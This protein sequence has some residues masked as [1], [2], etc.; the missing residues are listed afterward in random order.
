MGKPKKTPRS[1][2]TK[3]RRPS[4]KGAAMVGTMLSEPSPGARAMQQRFQLSQ[5]AKTYLHVLANPFD[6][7]TGACVPDE[8]EKP[9][10]KFRSVYRSSLAIG[11]AGFGFVMVDCLRFGLRDQLAITHSGSTYAAITLPLTGAEV[12]AINST[13]NQSTFLTAQIGRGGGSLQWRVVGCG[14]RVRY[15]GTELNRGGSIVPFR[16][17]ENQ[18][19]AG[20]G[21]GNMLVFQTVRSFPTDR[22]WHGTAFTPTSAFDTIYN[23][24]VPVAANTVNVIQDRTIA[25]AITGAVANNSYEYEIIAYYE[26]VGSIIGT[27]PSHSDMAGM[28]VAHAFTAGAN[29][30]TAGPSAFAAATKFVKDLV[31]TDASGWLATGKMVSTA[32]SIL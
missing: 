29:D 13:N 2:N 17:P 8:F 1:K 15:S 28:G 6:D 9:S 18:F 16:H 4:K 32:L 7:V 5:C 24:A 26:I 14:L 22:Q 19:I 23:D 3:R 21:T 20:Y 31:P 11:S 10:F 12:G 25:V 30:V 27:S